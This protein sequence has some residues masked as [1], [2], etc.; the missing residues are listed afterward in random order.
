MAS[1]TTGLDLKLKGK[2]T[3]VT[4][5]TAGIGKGIAKEFARHGAKVVINGRSEATVNSTIEEIAS[6]TGAAKED[7]YGVTADVGTPE[8]TTAFIE[9][10]DKIGLPVEVLVN[11]VG[12][13]HVQDFFEI[14]D[15]KWE[16]YFQV[17]IMS[18]VRLSRK[19][20]KPMLERNSGRIII[21]SSE[22]GERPLPHMVAYSVTKAAQVNFARGLAEITKGTAVTVNSVLVGPTWTEGVEKYIEGFAKEHNIPTP[23][24]GAKQYFKE[25]E[26]TSLLQRFIQPKEVADIVLFLAS[27]LAA[28]IN[29]AAQKAEGGII[30]HV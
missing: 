7:L 18:T 13:Y 10:V 9:A 23:E 20:L 28:A 30:R 2:L 21:I 17:N 3:L 27:P 8:G 25:H 24:E 11:N 5:S 26:R 22:V 16:Q 15:D 14:P 6:E 29:G 19:Y 1:A 12:I 4:G